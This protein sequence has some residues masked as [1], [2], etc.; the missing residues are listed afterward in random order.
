MGIRKGLTDMLLEALGPEW[1]LSRAVRVPG[2][3]VSLMK[4][5]KG[6]YCSAPSRPEIPAEFIYVQGRLTDFSRKSFGVPEYL[7]CSSL[8]ELR[9]RLEVACV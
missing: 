3:S 9:F 5:G 7:R 2:G 6:T 8:E 1:Y 4:Y